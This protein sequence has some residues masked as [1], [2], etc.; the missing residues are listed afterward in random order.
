MTLYEINAQYQ[1]FLQMVE[2]RKALRAVQRGC[3]KTY[4]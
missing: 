2:D 3:T 4:R 1:E